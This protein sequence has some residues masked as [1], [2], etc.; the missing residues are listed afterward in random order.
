MTERLCPNW[1]VM[2][3]LF[4]RLDE[5]EKVATVRLDELNREVGVSARATDRADRAEKRVAELDALLREV[6]DSVPATYY[7][8]D[9]MVRRHACALIAV[10]AYLRGR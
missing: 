7:E 1:N 6:W 5:L 10:G 8:K 4:E 9:L 3:A 2:E